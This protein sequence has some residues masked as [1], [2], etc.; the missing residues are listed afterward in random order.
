MSIIKKTAKIALIW[1]SL[2][3]ALLFLMGVGASFLIAY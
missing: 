3:A 1:S 2:A